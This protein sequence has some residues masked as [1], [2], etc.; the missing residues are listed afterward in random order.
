MNAKIS[1]FVICV[2]A[3]IHLLLNNLHDCSFNFGFNRVK[4][5]NSYLVQDLLVV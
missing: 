4:T 5:K 3:I 1:M 2:E